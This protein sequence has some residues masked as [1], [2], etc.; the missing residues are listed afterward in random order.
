MAFVVG[1]YSSPLELVNSL[2][3]S[4]MS[5]KESFVSLFGLDVEALEGGEIL[6]VETVVLIFCA[7]RPIGK[8]SFLFLGRA[9]GL[10]AFVRAASASC[11]AE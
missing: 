6:V 10:G 9:F 3:A 7:G 1:A 4:S 11:L 2:S 8:L 5:L